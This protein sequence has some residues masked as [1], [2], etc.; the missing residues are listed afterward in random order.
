MSVN[1]G[2]EV[3]EKYKSIRAVLDENNRLYDVISKVSNICSLSLNSLIT[4]DP[5]YDVKTNDFLTVISNSKLF[6]ESNNFLH[7]LFDD[8]LE[9]EYENLNKYSNLKR[10]V[11]S[12]L[13]CMLIKM[14][15]DEIY[16]LHARYNNEDAKILCILDEILTYLSTEL[17]PEETL[18]PFQLCRKLN[19]SRMYPLS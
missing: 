5:Y 4:V 1:K 16:G 14:K 12:S 11:R 10:Y 8:T 6:E 2:I 15:K 19:K 7:A 9:Y 13:N 17:E 3:C 18:Q